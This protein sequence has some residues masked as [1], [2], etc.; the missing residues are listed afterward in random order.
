LEK[1]LSIPRS[2]RDR[3]AVMVL[4]DE[5]RAQAPGARD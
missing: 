3:N 1:E 5:I 2:R 4:V